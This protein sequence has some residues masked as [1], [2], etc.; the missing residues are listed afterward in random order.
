MNLIDALDPVRR[1]P[2]IAREC[3][4]QPKHRKQGHHKPHPVKGGPVCYLCHPPAEYLMEQARA[5]ATQ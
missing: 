2:G 4:A 3:A 1:D 5:R